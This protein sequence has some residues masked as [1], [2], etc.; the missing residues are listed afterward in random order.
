MHREDEDPRRRP[1]REQ[2]ADQGHAIRIRERE[3]E[4]HDVGIRR[5][6]HA[7]RARS[8]GRLADDR[9]VRLLREHQPEALPDEVVVLDEGDPDPGRAIVLGGLV[10]R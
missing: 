4:Q 10:A 8:I 6:E 1:P 9:D 2:A 5:V 7:E 3:V